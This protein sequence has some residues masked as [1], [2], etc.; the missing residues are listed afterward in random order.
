MSKK[1]QNNSYLDSRMKELSISE[2][3]Y[4]TVIK[5]PKNNKKYQS[6]QTGKHPYTFFQSDEQDNIVINYFR[7]QVPGNYQFHKKGNKWSEAY[8][9]KRLKTPIVDKETGKSIK[10]LS[11]KDSG[12]APFFSPLLIDAYVNDKEIETLIITEGEFKAFKACKHNIPTIGLTGYEGFYSTHEKGTIHEDIIDFIQVCQVQ[13][14]I[15]LTDA[16]TLTI[17]YGKEKNLRQRPFNFYNAVKSFHAVLEKYIDNPNYK[18]R[19]LYYQ[20]I[21]T[22]YTDEA[23]GL[24]DLLV[25]YKGFEKDVFN[26]MLQFQYADKYFEGF[27]ITDGKLNKLYSHFGLTNETDFYKTYK[28]FIGSRPFRYGRRFYEWDGTDVKYLK[29]EDTDKYCRIAADWYKEVETMNKHGVKELELKKW[30]VGEIQRDYKKYPDFIDNI[31]KYDGFCSEPDF[32]PEYKRVHNNLRNV[33]DPCMH[34]IKEGEISNTINFLKHIF[35][36]EATIDNP[37]TGDPFT[38]ALDYLTIQYQNPKQMLPVPILVSK[39]F[40]TGKSTFIK[41]LQAVYVGNA[42]LLNNEMFRMSFNSHYITKYIIAIDEG[43][44]DVDKKSEKERLKQLVTADTAFLQYKGVDVTPF[45]FY[46]KLVICS[47]DAENIMKM[48]DGEDRWFVI[49]VPVPKKKDPD[50]EKKLNEEI[51]AWL[52]FIANREIHHKKEDRF[53]FKKDYIITEQY[54]LIVQGTKPR[55]E[56]II[57][58]FVADLFLTFGLPEIKMNAESIL[59]RVNRNIKYRIDTHELRRILEDRK[60]LA[61]QPRH[62]YQMPLYVDP[63]TNTISYDNRNDRPYQ[64]DVK[65][66]LNEEQ[67]EEFKQINNKMTYEKQTN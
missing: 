45:T 16:D 41:W 61:K 9:R 4:N 3:D 5:I 17:S 60:G 12:L 10:Y 49:K 44:L 18:L 31:P 15:F 1:K 20:H 35:G 36:G 62:R 42:V 6:H 58:E 33:Y 19:N 38:V 48:E 63:R 27:V 2:K 28:E 39:E 65:Q 34:N 54:K 46:G 57:E 22:K 52:N 51:P 23:K 32:T 25:K 13:N 26:D 67:M 43:F 14:V 7:P 66:W 37:I 11:P 47:N 53:W 40:G 30:K 59:E 29:H 55:A 24:D 50:L 56:L 64:L 8:N 21:K